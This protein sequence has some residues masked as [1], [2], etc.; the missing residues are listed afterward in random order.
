ML[1]VLDN[2]AAN[3]TRREMTKYAQESVQNEDSSHRHHIW[4][5]HELHIWD[6]G[7][8]EYSAARSHA[9]LKIPIPINYIW[10]LLVNRSGSGCLALPSFSRTQQGTLTARRTILMKSLEWAGSMHCS[11]LV[12]A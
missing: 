11:L 5:H 9:E 7:K 1:F 6:L 8:P 4:E 3:I 2:E 12:D 10:C